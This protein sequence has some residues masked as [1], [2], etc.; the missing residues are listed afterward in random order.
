[1]RPYLLYSV[2]V[3]SGK[4]LQSN[5]YTF[6]LFCL[7]LLN[8]LC[9][10]SAVG[11]HS[12]SCSFLNGNNITFPTVTV[13]IVSMNGY[14]VTLYNWNL[15]RRMKVLLEL[16]GHCKVVC[17]PIYFK[18]IPDKT[19]PGWKLQSH[20]SGLLFGA[21]ENTQRLYVPAPRRWVLKSPSSQTAL[22]PNM[23]FLT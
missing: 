4:C 20:Q 2:S 18:K 11:E 9:N 10:D 1:M 15:S 22:L 7:W 14:E 13:S 23:H 5:R 19:W 3:P 17:M 16:V 8:Y 21:P 12:C 6:N